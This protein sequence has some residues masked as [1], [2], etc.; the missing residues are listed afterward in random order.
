M[1]KQVMSEKDGMKIIAMEVFSTE[2]LLLKK[3]LKDYII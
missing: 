3:P 2:I 1:T